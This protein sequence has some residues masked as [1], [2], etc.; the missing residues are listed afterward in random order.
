MKENRGTTLKRLQRLKE[1]LLQT[2]SKGEEW[3]K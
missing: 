1:E 3:I 2:L